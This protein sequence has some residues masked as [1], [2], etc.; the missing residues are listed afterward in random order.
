MLSRFT[1]TSSC[2]G[3]SIQGA[4]CRSKV[5]HSEGSSGGNAAVAFQLHT[6]CQSST[7][8]SWQSLALGVIKCPGDTPWSAHLR[9]NK[10]FSSEATEER[11]Y[12]KN[13]IHNFI[14]GYLTQIFVAFLEPCYL[15]S[16]TTLREFCRNFFIIP[17]ALVLFDAF[18]CFFFAAGHILPPRTRVW[19]RACLQASYNLRKIE[20]NHEENNNLQISPNF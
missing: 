12:M 5:K 18:S 9:N 7:A 16:V 17:C 19:T 4:S 13:H 1:V 20:V 2:L 15:I 3:C 10:Y 8:L 6:F 14:K 11:S